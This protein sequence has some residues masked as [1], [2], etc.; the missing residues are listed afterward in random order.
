MSEHGLPVVP[1]AWRYATPMLLGALVAGVAGFFWSWAW[2]IAAVFAIL[3]FYFLYFFRDPERKAPN[4]PGVVVCPADG[5]VVSIEE[6]ADERFAEGRAWRIAIFLSIFD[7]HVQRAPLAGEVEQVSHTPGKFL[8][9]MNDKCSEDN[10]HTTIMLRHNGFPVV[11][12]QIAGAIARRIVCSVHPGDHVQLGDRIGLICFGSRVEA[13]LPLDAVLKVKQGQR[14]HGG[15]SV[16]AILSDQNP[17]KSS[18]E[19]S[20]VAS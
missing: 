17:L 19:S 7:V 10:E 15:Q 2:V 13:F 16:L 14:V 6:V 20:N 1:V 11:I 4:I 5:K 3:G 8:N 9:A 18:G 12:R